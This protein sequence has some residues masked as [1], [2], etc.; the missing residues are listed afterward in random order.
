[1]I[2]RERLLQQLEEQS[3]RFRLLEEQL[4]T[5]VEPDL[6]PVE[7]ER[8]S[9]ELLEKQWELMRKES[10]FDTTGL[11]PTYSPSWS[12]GPSERKSLST[13][14]NSPSPQRVSLSL[15]PPAGSLTPNSVTPPLSP[16]LPHAEMSSSPSSWRQGSGDN[17]LYGGGTGASSKG[18][19]QLSGSGDNPLYGGGTGASSKGLTLSGENPIYGGK[20]QLSGS[21]ENPIYGGGGNEGRR[22]SLSCSPDERS[23][24]NPLTSSSGEVE[25]YG[26]NQLSCSPDV[27]SWK[28]PLINLP[29]EPTPAATT[30]PTPHRKTSSREYQREPIPTPSVE[31]RSFEGG[32]GGSSSGGWKNPAPEPRGESSTGGGGGANWK[33]TASDSNPSLFGNPFAW[34]GA[35][36]S[37]SKRLALFTSFT[38]SCFDGTDYLSSSGD[39]SLSG[40]REEQMVYPQR[41]DRGGIQFS[42]FLGHTI[43]N[44]EDLFFE[45]PPPPQNPK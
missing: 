6:D 11:F 41:G 34:S 14:R 2:E 32:S 1:V 4:K 13:S 8:R 21:G 10:T 9:N 27:S 16:H 43:F 15:T 3:N 45:N 24:K 19:S 36:N 23:W 33:H 31:S 38:G 18:K 25:N 39:Y 7:K 20:S 44:H 17:P 30:P 5:Y 40:S 12:M 35:P 22:N 29:P 42:P 28:S 37:P 26:K